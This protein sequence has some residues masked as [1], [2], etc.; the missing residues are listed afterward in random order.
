MTASVTV[1]K[2]PNSKTLELLAQERLESSLQEILKARLNKHTEN[3]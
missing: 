1:D 2:F 3:I